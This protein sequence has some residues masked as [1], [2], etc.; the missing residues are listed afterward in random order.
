VILREWTE[1]GLSLT[2]SS[3][4]GVKDSEETSTLRVIA[5]ERDDKGGERALRNER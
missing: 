3:S 2:E 1:G 5:R 4:I